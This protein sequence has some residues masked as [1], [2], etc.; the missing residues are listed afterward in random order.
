MT[1]GTSLLPLSGLA[2]EVPD[3]VA[4]SGCVLQTTAGRDLVDFESG[5]WS[6]NLGHGHPAVTAA[7]VKQAVAVMHVGYRWSH[8]IVMRARARLCEVA[9][10]PDGQAVLLASGSEAVELGLRIA[11]S[12]TGR[13]GV[14]RFSGHYL[15]AYGAAGA[16]GTGRQ[17][18]VE[19]FD[20][21]GGEERRDALA[22]VGAVVLEPGNASGLVRLPD[23]R[24]VARVVDEVRAAGGL[25]VVDEVT[26]GFGRTGRW[27]GFQHLDVRPDVVAVGKGAGNGYPVSAV[28]VT[29][30]IA[31]RVECAG[32][33]YAQSHQDD[34]LG[35]AVMLAVI[36][37]IE[38]EGLLSATV[39]RGAQLTAGLARLAATGQGVRA[40]R[41]RGLMCAFDVAPGTAAQAQASLLDSGY[42]VGANLAHDTIRVYPPLVVTPAQIDGFVSAVR[43]YL[44]A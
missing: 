25:L 12:V 20:A 14:L 15:S 23:A 27:F 43:A 38:A 19:E 39:D 9:G 8:P 31:N 29:R 4:G 11:A 41:G 37:A 18:T 21:M 3:V 32:L 2:V 30:E 33:R 13:D 17:V 40:V 22:R 35:A 1:R 34:P 10:A 6:A 24:Q 44:T 26:T 36:E 16:P 5:V 42:L 7:L 28:V